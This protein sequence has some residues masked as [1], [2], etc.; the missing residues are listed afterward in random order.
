MKRAGS[1]VVAVALTVEMLV[2]SLPAQAQGDKCSQV[3]TELNNT[4]LIH[5]DSEQVAD[6]L[7]HLVQ[8]DCLHDDTVLGTICPVAQELSG[9]IEDKSLT[10]AL[11]IACQQSAG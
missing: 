2:A 8:Q 7:T 9:N 4:D 1:L 6:V 5:N 3:E 10:N 11:T